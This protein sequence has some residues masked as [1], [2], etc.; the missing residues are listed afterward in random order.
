[1]KFT[2]EKEG[3]MF[4]LGYDRRVC[5]TEGTYTPD[6]ANLLYAMVQTIE[7]VNANTPKKE[8]I[9]LEFGNGILDTQLQLASMMMDLYN[10]SQNKGEFNFK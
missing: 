6:Y 3:A 8:M 5:D 10:F 1:M 4:H 9:S 2:I 7:R